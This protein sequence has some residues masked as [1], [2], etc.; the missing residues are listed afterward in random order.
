MRNFFNLEGGFFGFMDK[1]ANLVWLN[2]LFLVCCIPIF[3][4]GAATTSL[5]YVTLKMVR[6]EES[7]ITKS[8]FKAFKQNFRQATGIWLLAMLVGVIFFADLRILTATGENTIYK[9]ILVAIYVMLVVFALT[10]TYVFPLLAK[11]DNTIKNTIKNSF[12][13]SIRHFPKTLL[14]IF[15]TVFPFV[16]SYFIIYVSPILLIIG[17]SG[18]AYITSTIYVKIFDRYISEEDKTTIENC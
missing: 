14:L 18:I 1:I 9:V 16:L 7:Y 11:F 5:F 12:L 17:S 10:M 2:I 13:I 6:N 15:C 4:I 3:T 8:F